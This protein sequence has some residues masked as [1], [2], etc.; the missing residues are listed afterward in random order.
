MSE[1]S[2]LLEVA[3][4]H[5]AYGHV[6]A[7]AASRS[8]CRRGGSSTLIGPNG[9]GKTSIL[10][11][12]AGLVRPRAGRCARR[13]GRHR[14]AG[15]PRGRRGARARAGGARDPRPDDDRGEPRAR[16]RA[17][18]GR[19]AL[20]ARSR[21]STGASRSSASGARR[22][23]GRSRAAQQQMLA[24][25]RALLARPAH[26]AARRALDGALADPR[27]ADLRD[28]SRRSTARART[29]LLVEQ[30]ARL[31]LAISDHAYVLERG[32][33]CSRARRAS[34]R[35]TR[36][37]RPPIWAGALGRRRGPSSHPAVDAGE[38]LAPLRRHS[39]FSKRR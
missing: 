12:L 23:R 28:R 30:N 33:S 19:G 27:A 35:R 39:S 37:S 34:S 1:A 6:E 38:M 24:F 11:A 22:S 20:R 36:A 4:L 17:A 31:A 25:A 2:P 5:V 13:A 3:D 15:A 14:P 29:I 26:P 10:S 9:A 18:P 7:V 8:A 21:S 32:G 16:R